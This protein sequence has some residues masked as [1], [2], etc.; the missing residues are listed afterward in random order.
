[1]V[2]PWF[3]GT[4]KMYSSVSY[5]AAQYKMSLFFPASKHASCVAARYFA[6]EVLP[7]FPRRLHH[8]WIIR[9]SGSCFINSR[10]RCSHLYDGT[11]NLKGFLT[12]FGFIGSKPLK[13]VSATRV[14]AFWQYF[15]QSASSLGAL[16]LICFGRSLFSKG[17]HLP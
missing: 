15:I 17:L 3:F 13:V 11:I 4:L 10:A 14:C 8:Q 12:L 16:Q 1:M 9:S 2:F 5:V 6:N 7:M